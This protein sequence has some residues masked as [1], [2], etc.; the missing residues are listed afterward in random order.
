MITFLK[1]SESCQMNLDDINATNH[2]NFGFIGITWKYAFSAKDTFSW[3]RLDVQKFRTWTD[4]YAGQMWLLIILLARHLH[5]YGELSINYC[6][7]RLKVFFFSG[8]HLAFPS[9][10]QIL[11]AF[12]YS[13]ISL[14]ASVARRRNRYPNLKDVQN[15]GS[16]TQRLIRGRSFFRMF[17][18][19]FVS[20]T[21]RKGLC[22]G[23]K[24]PFFGEKKYFCGGKQVLFSGKKSIFGGVK[25]YFFRVKK[26]FFGEKS[27]FLGGK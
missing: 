2:P 27:T 13:D 11:H 17:D 23:K 15:K 18:Q 16:D 7:R 1:T 12:N 25:K 24:S 4:I 3:R 26:S 21:W 14:V 6:E 10:D 5:A 19:I 22:G 8:N 20:A 9:H